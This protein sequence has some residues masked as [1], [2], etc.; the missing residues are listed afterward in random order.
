M[1]FFLRIFFSCRA[2]FLFWCMYCLG[3]VSSPVF[4]ILKHIKTRTTRREQ[5][6]ISFLRAFWG[7]LDGLF[8]GRNRSSR[9]KC[10]MTCLEKN[11]FSFT[12]SD[13]LCTVLTKCINQSVKRIPLIFTSSDEVNFLWYKCPKSSVERLCSRRFT[14]IYPYL[15]ISI[16]NLLKTMREGWDRWKNNRKCLRSYTKPQ[17]ER[18]GE[19]NIDEIMLTEKLS[20][21]Y[22]YEGFWRECEKTMIDIEMICHNHRFYRKMRKFWEKWNSR[23]RIEY[24]IF[25]MSEEIELC[26]IIFREIT[27]PVEMI[28]MEIGE[29]TILSIECTDM[30][31]HKTRHFENYMSFFFS[32]LMYF[33]E[34]IR[35]SRSEITT[36]IDRCLWETSL[37]EMK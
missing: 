10:I 9:D 7:Y 8:H 34:D 27:V 32:F 11:W 5:D 30:V 37:E 24:E 19:K 21:W 20:I 3:K 15:T 33:R 18:C 16:R 4:I 31:C 1:Y 6:N 23:S 13:T 22:I 12:E 28:R 14:I 17:S 29:N 25:G 2:L 35:E 36:Q 26:I